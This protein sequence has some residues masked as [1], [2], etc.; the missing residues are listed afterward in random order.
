MVKTFST[1]T[2][3]FILKC[4]IVSF[5]VIATISTQASVFESS[6]V[7]A[8][9]VFANMYPADSRHFS[10]K[11]KLLIAKAEKYINSKT[12]QKKD[13]LFR[14][15]KDGKNYYVFAEFYRLDK[16]GQKI[17]WPG[18]HCTVK[19]NEKFKVIDFFPGE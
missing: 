7:P 4:L 5:G 11:E 16:N 9:N 14:V 8:K 1:K 15:N 18:G 13:A 17:M 12:T 2:S 6:E 3:S 10:E 19:L